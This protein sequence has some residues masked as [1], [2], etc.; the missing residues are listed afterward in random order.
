MSTE[1]QQLE[2]AIVGSKS[3]RALLGDAV[4]DTALAPLRAK[5]AALAATSA[6][7]PGQMLRQVTILFLD[8]VGSTALSQRLDPEDTTR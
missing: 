1:R 3:Q 7:E 5:L 8:V 4:V 2:A 6:D